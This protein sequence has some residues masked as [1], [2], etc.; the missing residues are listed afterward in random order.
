MFREIHL[1][2]FKRPLKERAQ[3][4]RR[5]GNY[6]WTPSAPGKG[7][8]FYMASNGYA[9]AGHGGGMSLRIEPANDHLRGSRL[10]RIDGYYDRDG[11]G[12]ST[13]QPLIARL[14]NGRGFLA[15]WT[16][17]AGMCASLAPDIWPDEESAA[18]EAHRMAE[19]DAEEE[20]ERQAQSDDEEEEE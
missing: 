20:K 19:T 15:G 2:D 8:G 11:I 7:R 4:R 5:V 17:G 3:T 18:V 13:L 1:I 16:M 6:R 12:G 14:P 9:M 10:S